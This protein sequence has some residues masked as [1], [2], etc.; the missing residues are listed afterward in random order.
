MALDG[1]AT[2]SQQTSLGWR[3]QA[4]EGHEDGEDGNRRS[5][6]QATLRKGGGAARRPMLFV[7]WSPPFAACLRVPGGPKRVIR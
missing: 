1:G 4:V 5:E 3:Q 2:E 6:R 7:V